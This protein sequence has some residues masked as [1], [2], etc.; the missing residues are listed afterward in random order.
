MTSRQLA[1]RQRAV[2]SI[3]LATGQDENLTTRRLASANTMHKS[4]P[5]QPQ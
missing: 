5:N 2:W 3:S 4:V 1:A